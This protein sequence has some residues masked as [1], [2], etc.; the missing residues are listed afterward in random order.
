M[1][2]RVLDVKFGRDHSAPGSGSRNAAAGVGSGRV[3]HRRER[4]GGTV[5]AWGGRAGTGV[6]IRSPAQ[7]SASGRSAVPATVPL[8]AFVVAT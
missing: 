5:T 6:A 4:G 8:I 1:G 2:R 3:P 7:R